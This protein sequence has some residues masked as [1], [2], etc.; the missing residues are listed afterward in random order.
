MGYG[1]FRFGKLQLAHRV[2]F[3]LKHG[4]WPK[5]CACH[6]CDNPLCIRWSHLFE[7]TKADNNKDM[8]AKDRQV[9]GADHG[10][11]VLTPAAV[12]RIRLRTNMGDSQRK[13]ANN[14]GVSQAAVRDVL[15]GRCWAHIVN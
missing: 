11:S 1:G 5:P 7:G 3:F 14:E 12:K 15:S 4:R 9:R 10:K 8:L 6:H 13:I 2:A